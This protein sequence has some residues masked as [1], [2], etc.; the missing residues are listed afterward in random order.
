MYKIS[1]CTECT[2]TAFV[3]D[4]FV[5]IHNCPAADTSCGFG[6]DLDC[7]VTFTIKSRFQ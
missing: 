6:E 1:Y 7:T 2:K 5:K 3:D 4:A